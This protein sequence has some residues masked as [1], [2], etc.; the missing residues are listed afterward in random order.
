MLRLHEMFPGILCKCIAYSINSIHAHYWKTKCTELFMARCVLLYLMKSSSS[1]LKGIWPR[2]KTSLKLLVMTGPEDVNPLG[3]VQV[4]VPSDISWL[5]YSLTEGEVLSSVNRESLGAP[6]NGRRS[7]GGDGCVWTRF[8]TTVY[9]YI[10]LGS[11]TLVHQ[12]TVDDVTK[13]WFRCTSTSRLRNRPVQIA[14]HIK[15]QTHCS[16]Q[17]PV[18]MWMT[19]NLSDLSQRTSKNR[20]DDRTNT[21]HKD[22]VSKDLGGEVKCLWQWYQ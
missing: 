1:F 5:V 15:T 18:N 21:H 13:E 22:K 16:D 19:L 4:C 17:E 3:P 8:H 11:G 14:S 20:S 9:I 7:G 6:L 2:F 10:Y 12:K